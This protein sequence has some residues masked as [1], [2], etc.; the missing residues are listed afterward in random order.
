[1]IFSEKLQGL[2]SPSDSI[3]LKIQNGGEHKMVAIFILYF[4]CTSCQL[5]L[6]KFKVKGASEVHFKPVLMPKFMSMSWS[7]S[8]G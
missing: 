1:M 6:V 7:K 8:K 2:S 3:F 5:F 4:N